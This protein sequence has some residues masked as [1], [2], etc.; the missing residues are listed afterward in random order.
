M[1]C[2]RVYM[3][4]KT[5]KDYKDVMSILTSCVDGKSFTIYL[6]GR[7]PVR[8]NWREVGMLAVRPARKEQS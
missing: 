7:E 2:L 1:L 8:Y 3:K 5:V 4:D 6:G